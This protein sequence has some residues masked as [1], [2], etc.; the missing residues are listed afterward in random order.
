MHIMLGVTAVGWRIPIMYRTT[1][2]GWT[3]VHHWLLAAAQQSIIVNNEWRFT[4]TTK[5]TCS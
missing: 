4:F 5:S 2:N 3:M 1:T